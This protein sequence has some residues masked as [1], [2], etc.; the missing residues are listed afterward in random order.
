MKL[1]LIP[2]GE[3]GSPARCPGNMTPAARDAMEGTAHLY[4]EVGFHPPWVGYLADW[5]GDVVGSC[6][7]KSPPKDG[8]VEI[9]YHTFAEYE[10][11]GL[12]SEM[13]RQ[14]VQMAHDAD[15]Q[16]EVIA[17]TLPQE[18][19]S[20]RILSKLGFVLDGEIE[21]PGEGAAWQWRLP[22]RSAA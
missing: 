9:A 19:A 1:R 21:H 11:R 4:T 8:R 18:D 22:V 2:I 16:V 3:D 5:D 15:A 14:L 20:T 7:F 10:G 6:A 12:S 17:H 13:A